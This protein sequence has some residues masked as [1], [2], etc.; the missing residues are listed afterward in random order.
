M[1]AA[2]PASGPGRFPSTAWTLV[3]AAGADST[4]PEQRAAIERL[5]R[6]YWFP[7]YAFI[8]RRGHP[9]EAAQDLTQEFFL[10]VLSGTF[11]ARA[12][13]EKGRFRNFL[14]G[15]V[16]NFLANADDQ[17]SALKRGGGIEPLPFDFLT[18]ESAYVREP[19]HTETPERIFQR[20]WARAM[21]DRVAALLRDEFARDGKVSQFEELK[22]FLSGSREVKYAELAAQ[23]GIGESAI[24]SAILRLRK[25]YRD[26]LRSE[27]AAT[28]ADQR[29]IDDELRFLLRAVSSTSEEV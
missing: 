8:R 29:E 19:G 7:V 3:A 23:M 6:G 18:G 15:A 9:A 21:L 25:R 2:S 1:A 16:K 28:V 20:K 27:V 11:F 12:T 4:Q 5:C 24:K 13:S 17:A 10:R 22:G 14:L 26:L